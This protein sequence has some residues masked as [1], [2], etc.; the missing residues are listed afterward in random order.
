MTPYLFLVLRF[1]TLAELEVPL[2]MRSD[3]INQYGPKRLRHIV[4]HVGEQ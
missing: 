3:G 2:D 4:S 1:L